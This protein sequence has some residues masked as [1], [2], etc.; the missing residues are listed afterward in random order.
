MKL[1]KLY[2]NKP[3][4]DI[5]FNTK[6]G[7]INIILANA[8]A[9]KSETDTHSLGKTKL[10]ELIDFLL[11]KKGRVFLLS[12]KK[13]AGNSQPISR[14]N[15][16]IVKTFTKDDEKELLFKDYEFYLEILLNN[17]KYLTIKRIVNTA[18][19]ISFK[20]NEKASEGFIFYDNWDQENISL[21]KARKMLNNW[22]NFDFYKHTGYDYR[23]SI[24]YS[25]RL[26]GDYHKTAT[27]EGIFQ[28]S[29][30]VRSK[31]IYWKPFMFDLLGFN[32]KA[33][34]EKYE[35]EQE[36]KQ[37]K[38]LISE[39]EKDSGVKA[40]EK[41]S[42]VGQIDIK[43]KEKE[44]LDE[45]LESFNF[46]KQDQ[47]VI[48]ELVEDLEHKI[49][50]L[51]TQLFNVEYEISKLS[52]SIKNEF[53]FDIDKVKSLFSEVEI[54]FPEQLHKNY[55]ELITFNKKI[56][57]ERNKQIRNSLKEKSQELLYPTVL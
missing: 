34:K 37:Q 21:D 38:S 2:C 54:H 9:K 27:Q 25:L 20:L 44:E 17:G 35:L 47:E 4:K 19:K 23:K 30:F 42:I 41:D 55:E 8:K 12:Q 53:S 10:I 29:K 1:S 39:Q 43:Q 56:T 11:L 31:D 32:G 22:L 5:V 49:A 14:E 3:F 18:T 36:I 45:E 51:N 48:R 46:Y 28:L 13:V 52:Q 57:E 24:N 15:L 50:S 26:Q 7:G 16:Q 40:T 33:L 6:H